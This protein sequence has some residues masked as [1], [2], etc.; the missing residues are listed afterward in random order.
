L[1]SPELH[2]GPALT[3]VPG[4]SI[5]SPQHIDT[6]VS[7]TNLLFRLV[8]GTEKQALVDTANC[9]QTPLS[10]RCRKSVP[11][12]MTSEPEMPPNPHAT[13]HK[14]RKLLHEFD[15]SSTTN[16]PSKAFQQPLSHKIPDKVIQVLPHIRQGPVY[17]R[18]LDTALKN[19][20]SERPLMK[21]PHGGEHIGVETGEVT[22]SAD[23]E[24]SSVTAV[25]PHGTG[26]PSSLSISSPQSRETSPSS[27][28]GSGA[29][30]DVAPFIEFFKRERER[31]GV[32]TEVKDEAIKI[33]REW[34]TEWLTEDK[35]IRE[36]KRKIKAK[37]V[38]RSDALPTPTTPE[39]KSRNRP[40]L[41]RLSAEANPKSVESSKATS[42]GAKD[43]AKSA[44]DTSNN[45]NGPMDRVAGPN[46]LTGSYWNTTGGEMGRGNR[47]KSKTQIYP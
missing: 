28:M 31:G 44:A 11:A 19:I 29:L 24:G 8:R 5:N 18:N 27:T 33:L 40:K 30:V 13:R 20:L 6:Q 37:N 43:S 9:P 16:Q 47:R 45:E 25:A 22:P 4:Y 7:T 12:V 41:D 39:A 32:S 38:I 36:L 46:G 2:H 21:N 26:R 14:R 42:P 23:E 17:T 15:S 1:V 35:R 3:I 34:R 10:V